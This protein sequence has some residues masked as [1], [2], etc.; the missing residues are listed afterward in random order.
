MRVLKLGLPL[1]VL[2]TGLLFP[3]SAQEEED[4]VSYPSYA[5][6]LNLTA[7]PLPGVTINLVWASADESRVQ[8]AWEIVSEPAPST[9]GVLN[10]DMKLYDQYGIEMPP[11]GGVARHFEDSGSNSPFGRTIIYTVSQR[12]D[13]FMPYQAGDTATFT[14][15]AL[16]ATQVTPNVSEP[17]RVVPVPFTFDLTVAEAKIWEGEHT[18]SFN[19]YTLTL[20]RVEWAAS[21]TLVDIC[22]PYIPDV[23]NLYHSFY[24]P[25]FE[26]Y[27]PFP[28]FEL[29]SGEETSSLVWLERP[30]ATPEPDAPPTAQPPAVNDRICGRFIVGGLEPDSDETLEVVIED[31]RFQ[32]FPNHETISLVND[33]LEQAGS[34]GRFSWDQRQGLGLSSIDPNRPLSEFEMLEMSHIMYDITAKR[35]LG[36]WVFKV[37]L[38]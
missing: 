7:E 20:Q 18:I 24:T 30:E 11:V 4:T 14:F 10:H 38:E 27:L 9:A 23:N 1:L 3:I 12:D 8:V 26:T 35:I 36:P 32:M 29:I 13:I 37:T 2:F 5:I 21:A 34:V 22:F 28:E 33:A 15:I 25:H 6:P 17:R 19:G 31:L 16:L